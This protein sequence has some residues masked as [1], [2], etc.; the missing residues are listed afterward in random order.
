MVI[1]IK[2]LG[3]LQEK[4]SDLSNRLEDLNGTHNIPI[5]DLLTPVFLSGCSAFESADQLFAMSGYELNSQDDFNAIPEED[6][7]RYINKNTSFTGWQEMLQ[8]AAAM[9]VKNRMGI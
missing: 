1:E 3:E 9:W 2:G 8:A 7:V 6:W 5:N 4:F